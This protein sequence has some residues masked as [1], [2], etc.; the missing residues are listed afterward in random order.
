VYC[1]MLFCYSTPRPTPI[2][3][4]N[5]RTKKSTRLTDRAGA[6]SSGGP[7]YVLPG[8]EID[9]SL[10]P[11]HP[12]KPLRLGPGLRHAPPNDIIPTV[13]G[14]FVVERQKNAIRVETTSGR[15]SDIL[16]RHPS[17]SCDCRTLNM[18]KLTSICTVYS[19]SRRARHRHSPPLRRRELFRHPLRLHFLSAST[20]PLLRSSYKKDA[21]PA[22]Q[23]RSRLRAGLSRSQAHGPRVGVCLTIHWKI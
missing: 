1:Y 11:S 17:S 20:P 14:Q 7:I 9:A 19:S 8:D 2:T 22:R 5:P 12:K 6:M 4:T 15:V 23:R 3:G 10:I 13:A 18:R 21:P 16:A